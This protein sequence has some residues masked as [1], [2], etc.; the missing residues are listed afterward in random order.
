[1]SVDVGVEAAADSVEF[2]AWGSGSVLRS[3]GGIP[4]IGVTFEFVDG[5]GEPVPVT[6]SFEE[7]S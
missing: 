5:S 1:L 4:G 6:V 3:H 7:Q 2:P